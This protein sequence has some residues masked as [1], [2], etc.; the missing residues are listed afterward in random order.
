VGA[1]C[2][3][4]PIPLD[5]NTIVVFHEAGRKLQ[6]FGPMNAKITINFGRLVGFIIRMV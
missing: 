6:N 4:N 3:N 1:A 5:L 2:L